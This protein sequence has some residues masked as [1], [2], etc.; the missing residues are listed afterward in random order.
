MPNG[1]ENINNATPP[2][3][4]VPQ[5]SIPR[6]SDQ[7]GLRVSLIPA[8]E[9]QR[10]DPVLGFRNFI[11]TIAVFILVVSG[12]MGYLWYSVDKQTK[13]VTAIDAA[14]KELT[15]QSKGLES[16]IVEAKAMQARLRSLGTLLDNHKTGLKI[17]T[18]FEA[19]T[20]PDVAY[21]A[22]SVAENGSVS[23]AAK[24]TSFESYAAQINHLRTLKEVK[25]FTTSGV[26]PSYDQDNN[27]VSID[28]NITLNLNESL[29]L[30]TANTSDKNNVTPNPTPAK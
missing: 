15:D 19:N 29:F 2:V 7:V 10:R 24:T 6:P 4:P 18:F 3:P 16:S 8:D 20:L 1:S 22:L 26:S 9:L 28:F 17:L 21:S 27:I 30:L 11:I 13:E 25:S 12:T 23:V 5:P 14:A